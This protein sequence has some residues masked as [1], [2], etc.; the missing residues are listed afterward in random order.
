MLS[1]PIPSGFIA[2]ADVATDPVFAPL[3]GR[4]LR[5]CRYANLVTYY[6]IARKIYYKPEDLEALILRLRVPAGSDAAVV[7]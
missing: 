1:C 5:T 7:S 3:R 2:E 6:V 4:Y